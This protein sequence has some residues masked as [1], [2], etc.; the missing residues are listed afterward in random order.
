MVNIKKKK[1]TRI[2]VGLLCTECNAQNYVTTYNK[3]NT[4]K[5]EL[6]KYCPHERRH[7]AHKVRPKL[8]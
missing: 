7:V 5:L 1:G 2:L 8:K 4:P 6:V 3:M